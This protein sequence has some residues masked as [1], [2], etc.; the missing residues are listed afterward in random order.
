HW[1]PPWPGWRRRTAARRRNAPEPWPG[2]CSAPPHARSSP[3]SCRPGATSSQEGPPSDPRVHRRRDRRHGRPGGTLAHARAVRA[4]HPAAGAVEPGH[5]DGVLHRGGG[6]AGRGARRRRLRRRHPRGPG[7]SRS[8]R[9]TGARTR[10]HCPATFLRR[11]GRAP[12][13]LGRGAPRGPGRAPERLV[14]AGARD[15]REQ[16]LGHGTRGTPERLPDLAGGR[17]MSAKLG[18]T[19]LAPL[20]L[21]GL[22]LV[23]APFVV[24][25]Q[26]RDAALTP[27][28]VNDLWVGGALAGV[29][30]LG[31][32]GYAAALLRELVQH[33]RHTG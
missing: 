18:V 17:A 4:R 13:A 19:A 30:F 11:T 20:L 7:R 15:A 29:S 14:E 5:G 32:I 27:A 10:T 9:R 28:T 16:L 8:C 12:D 1:S 25:Y 23:A 26:P 3:R 24:G 6:D 31:L 21:A 2:P 33:G 22:W